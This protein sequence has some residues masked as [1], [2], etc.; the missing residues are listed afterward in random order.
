[1]EKVSGQQEWKNYIVE[2]EHPKE[3]DCSAV[4][5]KLTKGIRGSSAADINFAIIGGEVKIPECDFCSTKYLLSR[6]RSVAV[7]LDIWS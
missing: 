7:I 4:K 5:E 6:I 2:F 3:G 1:M